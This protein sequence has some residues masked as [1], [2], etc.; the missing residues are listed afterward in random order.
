MTAG[1]NLEVGHGDMVTWCLPRACLRIQRQGFT[2]RMDPHSPGA[3][4]QARA[5]S[6]NCSRE[7]V[8][9]SL[10]G[11]PD[12]FSFVTRFASL[13]PRMTELQLSLAQLTHG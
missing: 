11:P 7:E 4:N 10:A 6:C 2:Q 3:R 9:T 5:H 13:S 12:E 1:H 8:S